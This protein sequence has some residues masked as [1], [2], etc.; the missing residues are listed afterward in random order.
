M[1]SGWCEIAFNKGV[2]ANPFAAYRYATTPGD[3]SP[4]VVC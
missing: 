1:L 3:G 4:G 2:G